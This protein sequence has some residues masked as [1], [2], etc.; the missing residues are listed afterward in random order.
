[1][2]ENELL[3][4]LANELTIPEMQP[5]EITVSMLAKKLNLT[6][7]MAYEILE[8]KIEQGILKKRFV[9]GNRQRVLAYS[10]VEDPIDK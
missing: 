8:K 3:E 7:R 6:H 5:D 1:M 9:R 2:T 10:K 4:E